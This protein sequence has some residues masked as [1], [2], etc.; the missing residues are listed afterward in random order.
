[1]EPSV[2]EPRDRA[3]TE[4]AQANEIDIWRKASIERY[5]SG[6]EQ[7]LATHP[8]RDGFLQ[9]LEAQCV[10]KRE[11]LSAVRAGAALEAQEMDDRKGH[12]ALAKREA[13][14]E[15]TVGA[16][17][18]LRELRERS[19]LAYEGVVVR[20][21]AL[22]LKN[23][24]VSDPV[25]ASMWRD[26]VEVESALDAVKQ[27]A[28]ELV[29]S[30]T[31]VGDGKTLGFTS[32]VAKALL[33]LDS[34]AR[35]T[36][37][38]EE[39]FTTAFVIGPP[40]FCAR[41]RLQTKLEHFVLTPII[42]QLTEHQRIRGGFIKRERL[43]HDLKSSRTQL[44]T[45]HSRIGRTHNATKNAALRERCKGVQTAVVEI[46]TE[47]SELDLWLL[48]TM[49]EINATRAQIVAPVW[50]A[51]R[52][53]HREYIRDVSAALDAA[54][55]HG[56]DRPVHEDVAVAAVAEGEATA[57]AAPGADADAGADA[58]ASAAA[59]EEVPV[60]DDDEGWGDDSAEL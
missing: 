58:P 2:I 15:N 45:L 14:A 60:E 9:W 57:A 44:A 30:I 26:V 7:Y 40:A 31:I 59:E 12:A 34:V 28:T 56:D 24:T 16:A 23:P 18:S 22:N 55:L 11:R 17:V 47:L 41:T 36:L 3:S 27:A 48:T 49:E 13:A 19:R 10:A 37:N 51:M 38:Y 6:D 21:R 5:D 39:G 29:A 42:L 53:I 4:N 33:P 50:K 32:G 25:Q 43:N 52:H 1:M 8:T 35:T 54:A 20:L 46:A